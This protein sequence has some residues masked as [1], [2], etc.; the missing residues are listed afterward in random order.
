MLIS[1]LR[2]SFWCIGGRERGMRDII[3]HLSH[4]ESFGVHCTAFKGTP[5]EGAGWL[6]TENVLI[7]PFA[8]FVWLFF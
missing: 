4:E 6:E 5:G 2:C 1:V 3:A 8:G 7:F